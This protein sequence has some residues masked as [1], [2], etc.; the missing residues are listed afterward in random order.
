MYVLF[1]VIVNR[2]NPGTRGFSRVFEWV[3]AD[4]SRVFAIAL[5]LSGLAFRSPR[6]G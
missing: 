6:S 3:H 5:A 2:I 4:F 1:G